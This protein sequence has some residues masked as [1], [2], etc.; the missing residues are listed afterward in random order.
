MTTIEEQAVREAQSAREQEKA[1]P[2]SPIVTDEEIDAAIDIVARVIRRVEDTLPSPFNYIA[3]GA[4]TLLE[5]FVKPRD[6]NI[7]HVGPS[8]DESG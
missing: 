5:V 6:I 4:L 8:A 7:G 2:D 1:D 3:S